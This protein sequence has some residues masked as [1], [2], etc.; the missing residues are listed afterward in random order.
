VLLLSGVKLLEPPG[1]GA[2][3]GLVA[4]TGM[5]L[6]TTSVVRRVAARPS[7]VAVERTGP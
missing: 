1:S 7:R 2:L 5:T 4:L 6:L 3:L